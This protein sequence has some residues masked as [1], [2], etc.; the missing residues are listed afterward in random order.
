[1]HTSEIESDGPPSCVVSHFLGESSLV[2][3]IVPYFLDEPTAKKNIFHQ[4]NHFVNTE[5]KVI[6]SKML[7]E[8]YL[9]C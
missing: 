4:K 3:C 7:H 8:I 5:M 6:S 1:M 9:I 2:N